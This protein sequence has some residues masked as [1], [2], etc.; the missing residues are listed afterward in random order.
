VLPHRNA[1]LPL[2]LLEDLAEVVGA[3]IVG[4]PF[5]GADGAE[6]EASAAEGVVAEFE[7]VVGTGR[8]D[9]VLTFGVAYSV[10]CDFDTRAGLG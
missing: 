3:G 7:D 2:Q 8:G 1:L 10:R 9:D 6:R 5:G 4:K